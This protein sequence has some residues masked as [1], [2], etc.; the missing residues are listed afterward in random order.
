MKRMNAV[1]WIGLFLLLSVL[2]A[3]ALLLHPFIRFSLD[4]RLERFDDAQAV[5]RS[6]IVDAPRLKA[7]AWE[8][9]DGYARRTLSAYYDKT[10]PFDEALS[11]L[12]SLFAIEPEQTTVSNCL[13]DLT[14]METAR[15]DLAQAD[16]FTARQDYAQAIPLYR[17]ALIAEDGA[18]SRLSQ[19]EFAFKASRIDEAVKAMAEERFE[20]AEALLTEATALLGPDEEIEAAL[21]DVYTLAR[22][23]AES[24]REREARRLMDAGDVKG[25]FEY[26]AACRIAE[27]DDYPLSYLEQSL[28]HEYEETVCASALA[29]QANGDPEAACEQL[30]QGLLLVDSQR[31]SDL[32]RQIRASIPYLLGEMA[33]EQDPSS[34]G[35]LFRDEVLAD[36]Q[37]NRYE[38]SFAAAMGTV[39]FD[40]NGRF[41]F[42]T[43]TVAFPAG[44]SSDVYRSSATLQILGDGQLLAEFKHMDASSLPMP[45]SIGVEGIQKIALV[46]TSEGANGQRDWGRFATVFDGRF[47]PPTP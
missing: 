39:S 4:L 15:N 34:D 19:A 2:L 40:L 30:Q 14:A 27:P 23:K 10:L 13:R 35:R 18:Q 17:Q 31:M 26:V 33:A 21:A 20:D 44:E 6:H 22:S 3:G 38:H 32:L 29:L 16:A 24:D 45:F 25:A 28:R 46:W 12:N 43:G 8:S 5:Y 47:L 41:A 1:K 11:T 37:G 42:F 36:N 7:K 9:L